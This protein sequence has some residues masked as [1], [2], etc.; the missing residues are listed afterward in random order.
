[1]VDEVVASEGVDEVAIAAQVRGGDR[2]ELAVAGRRREP[3]APGPC[4]SSPSG[5]N[6]AA[7]TRIIGSSLVR[8][9]STIAAIAA[10][11][12]TTS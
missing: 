7:A 8:D 3:L 12:P 4:R 11:S 9:A 1:M 6:S 10:A 2:D 5:A